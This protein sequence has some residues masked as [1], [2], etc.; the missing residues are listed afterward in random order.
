MFYNCKEATKTAARKQEEP[1]S[2]RE[3]LLL[4]VHLLYCGLCRRFVKQVAQLKESLKNY[5][6]LNEQSKPLVTLSASGKAKISR[7]IHEELKKDS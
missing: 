1:V 2:F 4:H 3:N 7:A 5:E 6:R